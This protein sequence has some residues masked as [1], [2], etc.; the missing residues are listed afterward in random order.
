M[1]RA[2]ADLSKPLQPIYRI[3]YCGSC[4]FQGQMR[5]ELKVLK[6]GLR[7]RFTCPKCHALVKID[8]FKNPS[9]LAIET[10]EWR[11]PMWTNED[12]IEYN[13]ALLGL[14]Y[15]KGDW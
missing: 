15:T 3:L 9:N 1:S 2:K 14:P 8:W 4:K 6:N 13:K 12:M 10:L 5:G 7:R 11:Q